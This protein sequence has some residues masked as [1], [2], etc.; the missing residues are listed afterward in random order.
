LTT[1]RPRL[2]TIKNHKIRRMKELYPEVNVKLFKR[3][4]LRDLMIK[5]GLYSEA[6]KLWGNE[7][8]KDE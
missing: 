7:A 2:N 3:R 6:D 8:L 5:F 1:R 4:D